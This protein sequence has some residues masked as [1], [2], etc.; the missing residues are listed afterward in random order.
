MK[1][2]P[3][4][5]T[6]AGRIYPILAIF[7]DTRRGIEMANALSERFPGTSVLAIRHGEK[8]AALRAL[9]SQGMIPFFGPA[10]LVLVVDWKQRWNKT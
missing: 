9:H 6:V 4:V 2:N 8:L 7:P 10:L 5:R 3:I 1:P